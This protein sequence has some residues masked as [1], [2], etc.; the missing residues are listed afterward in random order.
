M[1]DNYFAASGSQV[2]SQ[3]V[4]RAAAVAPTLTWATPASIP[5]GTPLSANQL[6]AVA[7]DATGAAVPGVYTYVPPAGT[8]LNAG[9]QTLSVTFMPTDLNSFLT[10]SK[11][12]NLTV[13]QGPSA[14]TLAATSGGSPVTTVAAGS[15]VTATATVLSGGTAV[16]PG[17]VNFC[18]A[19][20]ILCDSVHRR[21]FA[22]LTSSGTA[23]ISFVPEIGTHSYK[24]V[25]VGTKN[26]AASVSSNETVTVTGK[27]ATST[28]IAASGS[29]GNYTLTATTVGLAPASVPPTG[30]VSFLD[31]TSNN[32]QLGSANLGASTAAVSL[33]ASSSPATGREPVFIATGD[34]NGDGRLDLAIANYGTVGFP[35]TGRTLTILLGNGDGTFH[36]APS[37]ATGNAPSGIAV[38]DFNGDGRTDLAVTNAGDN[39]L[40]IL[41]GN[42]DGTFTA[43]ASPAT[44]SGPNGIATGDFN[45]D[46]IADLA[47]TN[48]FDNTVSVLLG[49]G[50]GTFTSVGTISTGSNPNT[51]VVA[52]FNRDGN[53][54][55]AVANT[56]EVGLNIFTGN[57]DGTFTAVSSPAVQNIT[58]GDFAAVA[59]GDFNADGKAD[60]VVVSS[61][62][63]LSGTVLLGNGD[64]TFSVGSSIVG[65]TTYA[66]GVAVH[67]FNRDGESDIVVTDDQRTLILLSNGD[68]TFTAGPSS[69]LGNN[70]DPDYRAI[71]AG[72]FNGDGVPDL[73]FTNSDL[74]AVSVV[75]T[76]LTQTAT[77]TASGISPI[78]TGVHQVVAS[79]AGGLN[80]AVSVSSAT[81]LTALQTTP[82]LSWGPA[83]TSIVYGTPLGAQELNAT[84]ADATGAAIPGVFTYLP[85]AGAVLSAGT[86]KLTVTF[87]PT[88]TRFLTVSGS[89]TITV[90]QATPV[91]TWT[92]PASI[93]YGTA[94]SGAQLNASVAGVSGA[95]LP[96]V[97][98]YTPVAGTV[99]SPGTQTLSVSFAPTDALDYTVVNG[100]VKLLVT[101]V[102]LSS[103]TPNTATLGDGNKT[104]TLT[105]AGFVASSVVQ[106]NGVSVATAFVNPTTL[107]AVIPAADF[108]NVGT[109]QITVLDPTIPASSAALPLVVV[110]AAASVTLTGPTTTP[111][112]SQPSVSLTINNPYPI[113]LTAVFTLA[114]TPAV[115]PAVDDPAIQFASGGRTY[116]F[117][118]AAGQTA[119]PPIALQSGTVA[120]TI[121]IPLV[122]T[123]GGANVTPTN[124][125]PVVITIPPAVPT[126]STTT[127]TRNGSQLTLAIHGF[128]NTRE[129]TQASFQFLGVSG[130]QIDTPNVTAA[131]GTLFTGWF[132]SAASAQ[133][134]STFTYTQVFN[135]SGSAAAIGSV[136]VT[137]TNSVGVS[138]VQT[139]Q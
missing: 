34:F 77:A 12:V 69:P 104:I 95:V 10:V 38:G 117:T 114:F 105:G 76:Q 2:L 41:L 81:N 43:A 4:N 72:D 102:T 130:A 100:S 5:Y 11:T 133:Y 33:L 44:G 123:A 59:V 66:A 119:V 89:A 19:N 15:V 14:I 21:T 63:K 73:A 74:D 111:P 60:L 138:T 78:G 61:G 137:L 65:D 48:T 56:G 24:A 13:L 118:V 122:L 31:E 121:T 128:S 47:V 1:G 120:G 115:T 92:T 42:G 88:D 90:T 16:A 86:Q 67:D 82:I 25:F 23:T 110:A 7:T 3:V 6:D 87:V 52:D 113:P 57:G 50:D 109:L 108:A 131:V 26:Y 94:L 127:L 139:A 18:D 80:F 27:F 101:G 40:S 96:G 98:T 132:S 129:I 85:A 134:G 68:G 71:A 124:L 125:Q 93:A 30:K 37:P 17:Q 32:L 54:D 35:A 103:F 116:T 39:T 62:N 112:G 83:V 46:G 136:Q 20:V 126:V 36:A 79:Y 53:A 97:A 28:A 51:V 75:L 70:D 29:T 49:N 107:T 45:Q 84:A 22:Q 106:L 55:L 99:L 135:V 64:G 8:I 9:T 91:L 58:G